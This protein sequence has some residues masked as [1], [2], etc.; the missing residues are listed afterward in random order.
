MNIKKLLNPRFTIKNHSIS[1][2]DGYLTLP[3]SEREIKVLFWPLPWYLSPYSMSLDLDN[4]KDSGKWE[5]SSEWAKFHRKI[6]EDYPI[7]YFIRNLDTTKFYR[8]FSWKWRWVE[9]EVIY[10]VK[11]Y[12]NS[13]NKHIQ[14][15][16]PNTWK[17]EEK[18]IRDVL[19]AIFLNFYLPDKC[20]NWRVDENDDDFTKKINTSWSKLALE[21][22]ECYEWLDKTHKVL[23]IELENAYDNLPMGKLPYEEKYKR[24]NDLETQIKAGDDKYLS[25]IL[26][27]REI[28]D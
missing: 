8:F 16:I 10:S 23:L 7:Q 3:K 5:G 21:A 22:D 2:L 15:V 4:L 25:W 19:V 17:S 18:I 9:D 12:F 11:C 1:T 28:F 27:N 24:T 6:K 14:K 13:R 26:L 20:A